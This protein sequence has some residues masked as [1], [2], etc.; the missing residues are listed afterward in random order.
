[1]LSGSS[2]AHSREFFSACFVS[3]AR[4]MLI[5]MNTHSGSSSARIT[6]SIHTVVHRLSGSSSARAGSSSA[7]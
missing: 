4:K 5:Y 2:S 6:L 3:N 7:H 1:M